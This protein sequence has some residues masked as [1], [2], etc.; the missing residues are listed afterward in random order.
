MSEQHANP[1][2]TVEPRIEDIPSAATSERAARAS[3]LLRATRSIARRRLIRDSVLRMGTLVEAAIRQASRAL[4]NHDAATA[5]DVI[6][7]RR[8]DQ[9]G[10]ARRVPADRGRHRHPAARREGSS[11]SPRPRPRHLRAR[12]DGRPRGLGGEGCP[13]ARARATARRQPPPSPRWPS[14]RPCSSTGS[15]APSSTRTRARHG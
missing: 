12:A 7:G 8:V 1:N 3:P 10:A 5:L 4:T 13:Q 11:L 6:H 9:R 2:V 14:A 15:S